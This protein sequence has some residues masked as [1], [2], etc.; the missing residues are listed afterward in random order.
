[1]CN[2]INSKR[3]NI[4]LILL[5]IIVIILS[6]CDAS[7]GNESNEK[8][9]MIEKGNL[10]IENL[11][12]TQGDTF[13]AISSN[14]PYE[15]NRSIPMYF[16]YLSNISTNNNDITRML[17]LYLAS[18]EL[19]FKN[20]SSL[21][22]NNLNWTSAEI[23]PYNFN[24]NLTV[25]LG[26]EDLYFFDKAHVSHIIFNSNLNYVFEFTNLLIESRDT[27]SEDI[28]YVSSTPV[29]ATTND[30]LTLYVRYG[31]TP[32]AGGSIE[33]FKLIF[34]EEFSNLIRYEIVHY[35]TDDN[36]IYRFEIR[37]YFSEYRSEIFF[38]PFIRIEHN[39]GQQSYLLPFMPVLINPVNHK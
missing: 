12:L 28:F 29:I 32:F 39:N 23:T 38:R 37:K 18:I 9:E 27:I 4:C 10:D 35:Y 21:K 1:M 14:D 25:E 17:N 11:I 15:H 33:G 19:Y 20:N 26:L 22:L 31:I 7:A 30:D 3:R 2:L 16:T 5:F 13:I 36:G 6:G 24:I 34:P 8:E